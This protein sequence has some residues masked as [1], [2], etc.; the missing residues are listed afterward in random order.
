MNWKIFVALFF[1]N[2]SH[3]YFI[4]ADIAKNMPPDE[5]FENAEFHDSCYVAD[6]V[7]TEDGRKDIKVICPK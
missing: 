4:P 7:V 6:T 1:L 3:V 2:C 5:F